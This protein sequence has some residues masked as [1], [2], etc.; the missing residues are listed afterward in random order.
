VIPEIAVF[1]RTSQQ[2][3]C[4]LAVFAYDRASGHPVWQSGTRRVDSKSRDVWVLGAG[5]FQSGTIYDGTQLSGEK[6]NVPL[7]GSDATAEQQT[8]PN[9]VWVAEEI[10]FAN[11]APANVAQ[12]SPLAPGTSA[13]QPASFNQPVTPSMAPLP[14]A[15]SPVPN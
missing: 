13:E 14:P 4:K 11:P 7:A 9:K 12:G 15:A 2:G 10:V 1:K 8:R 3:V 6:L 5:P